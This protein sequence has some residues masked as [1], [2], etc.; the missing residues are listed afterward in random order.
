MSDPLDSF[1]SEVLRRLSD[2][3]LR[4]ALEAYV[5]ESEDRVKRILTS[6]PDISDLA[7]EVR[8][9]K[10]SSIARLDELIEQAVRSLKAVGANTYL[11]EDVDQARE[12]VG[13]IVGTGRL[14][15]IS[16]S[17][18]A[19][20]I[21][22]REHL[23]SRGNEVWETDLGQ[24]LV[25]LEGGKPMHQV[26]P[27]IHMTVRR[28]ARLL[29]GLG[30]DVRD[31]DTPQA[32]V[33][34]VR[35]FLRSK[36]VRADV[37]VSGA[38]AVAAR[39]G[40]ILLVENEGNIRMVTNLPRVHI[41]IAGV[42]KVVPTLLDAFKVV[43]VQAAFAGLFPPTYVSVI[44][45]PSSTGDIGH[46][47]VYGAHGPVEVHVILLDHGRREALKDTAL[48]EQLRCVRCGYCQFVCPVWGQVANGWGG[49][50]YGGPMGV[51]W[52]AIT[53][54]VERGAALAMLCLGCGRC[55]LACPVE[56]PLSGIIADLKSRYSSA[57]RP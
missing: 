45:G 42:E 36:F 51:G 52:T 24:L 37:G 30:L 33:A 16:K 46:R 13:R 6:M 29:R 17:M 14:V 21:G 31:T 44:A 38:N 19:E 15:V 2:R 26:A 10:E 1:A 54:G 39:E 22:L 3:D 35:E 53:E 49:T 50:A 48:R 41:A 28:V 9:I 55:D 47:R 27:A 5:P 56:I 40:A 8:R 34:R 11:A 4:E 57:P 12:I 43:L 25:Q 23:E 20:E 18:T 32:M 7:K